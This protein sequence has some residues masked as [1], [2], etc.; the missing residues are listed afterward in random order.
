MFNGHF[1]VR[2]FKKL[3]AY[4]IIAVIILPVAVV[5]LFRARRSSSS[6]PRLAWGEAPIISNPIWARA[7]RDGG[8]A[9]QSYTDG[10]CYLIN[11]RAD[12]DQTIQERFP[13]C[14]LEFQRFFGFFDALLNYDVFFISFNGFFLGQTPFWRFESY[15]F[16]L[17]GK[18]VVVMP[19]GLDAYVYRRVRSMGLMQGLMM[20][21]PLPSRQQRKLQKKVDYWCDNANAVIAGIMGPDGF[22]RWDVLVPSVVNINEREWTPSSRLSD[23]DGTNGTVY[24]AHA[25]NHRG[26]KGSEFVIEAVRQ[27]QEEGLKV[28]L[29]LIEKKPNAEVKRIFNQDA[30]ILVE[31]LICP[32]HGLNALEGM[33]SA[34]P[35][36]CNLEDDDYLMPMRRWSYFEQCPLVSASPENIKCVLRKLVVNPSLRKALGAAGREYIEKY[37][38]VSA[39]QFFYGKVVDYVYGREETLSALFHPLLSA[40]I[41]ELG[42]IEHPLKSSRLPD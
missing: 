28:E 20:S 14:S 38:G 5:M 16:R 15:F 37:H 12:Y 26:F 29:I 39:A 11:D 40:R 8:Y 21:I 25:P 42:R 18:K 32:G 34:L 4:I 7:L 33:A 30:D 36:V 17:A 27:L 6:D 10:Y 22:G 31:Q 3:L 23:A 24:V 19:F 41:L 35:V 13:R 2:R 1:F 9:S